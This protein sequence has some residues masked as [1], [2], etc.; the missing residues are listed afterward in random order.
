MIEALRDFVWQTVHPTPARNQDLI[1]INKKKKNLSSN[2]F[3]FSSEPQNESK[4]LNKYL[5]LAW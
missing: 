5:D 1:L 2:G 4:K 3:C